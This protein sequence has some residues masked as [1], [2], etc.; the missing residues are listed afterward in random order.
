[1][2]PCKGGRLVIASEECEIP[3]SYNEISMS[4]LTCILACPLH[5]CSS[6]HRLDILHLC[7]IRQV[8]AHTT[9][10]VSQAHALQGSGQQH[11]W[12]QGMATKEGLVSNV[13]V[14]LAEVAEAA[15][16]MPRKLHVK[17]PVKKTSSIADGPLPMTSPACHCM[18][19]CIR[20]RAVMAWSHTSYSAFSMP[21]S[22]QIA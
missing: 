1:M 8:A 10:M 11:I 9:M 22:R 21:Q 14:L 16:G 18:C 19:S 6:T 2:A 7:L 3:D 4:A 17:H 13:P 20:R 15:R 12:L 5:S